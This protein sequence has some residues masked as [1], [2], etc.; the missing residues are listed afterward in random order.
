MADTKI[1]ALSAATVITGADVVPISRTGNNFGVPLSLL[2]G[3]L[4]GH[5]AGYNTSNNAVT[6][7]TQ[8]DITAGSAVD[9]TASAFLIGSGATID[10]TTV[11]VLGLDTGTL[12]NN[13]WYHIFVIGKTTGVTSFI[14]SASTTP[15]FANTTGYSLFRRIGSVKTNGSA[16]IIAFTQ[17]GDKFS[18]AASVTD[19][20]TASMGVS[21][22]LYTL[23]VPTGVKV[24]PLADVGTTGGNLLVFNGDEA[25]YAPGSGNI[26]VAPGWL[27]LGN[28]NMVQR[29]T[30]VYTDTSARI[31]VYADATTRSLYIYTRGWTDT[32]GRLS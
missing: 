4:R 8:I 3:A 18:W 19:V 15:S 31:R 7:N 10:C 11:G 26:T 5:L 17:I 14:A 9:S 27:V 2:A 12:T 20:S 16:Q 30:D 23:T 24:C 29:I 25:G 22:A 13:T 28:F 32:R 6:P 1:S 21:N